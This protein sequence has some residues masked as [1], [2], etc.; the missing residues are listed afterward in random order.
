MNDES[1][2]IFDN[3]LTGGSKEQLRLRMEKLLKICYDHNVRLNF[4]KSFIG[5]RTANYFGYELYPNGYRLDSKRKAAMT[6]PS[7]IMVRLRKPTLRLLRASWASQSTS[8]PS[9]RT[10]PP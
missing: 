8:V 4:K 5:H 3:I 6:S 10:M 9:Q 2:T 1:I 7:R